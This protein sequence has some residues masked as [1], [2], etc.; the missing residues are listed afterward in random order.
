MA[1][2]PRFSEPP[3]LEVQDLTHLGVLPPQS[4][5]TDRTSLS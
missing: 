1:S 5:T 2:F 4:L 3:E